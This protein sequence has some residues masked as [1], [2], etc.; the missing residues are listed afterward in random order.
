MRC[1]WRGEIDAVIDPNVPTV[2]HI[3]RDGRTRRLFREYKAE[4]QDY[5]RKTEI[6]PISH[7]VTLRQHFVDR[8]P[9]APVALLKAFRRARDIADVT[10]NASGLRSPGPDSVLG[11]RIAMDEQRALMGDDYFAYDIAHNRTTLEAMMHYAHEQFLN[12]RAG[13]LPAPVRVGG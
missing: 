2:D 6:F 11:E 13:R 8:H 5:F 9:G 3:R 10:D 1:L 12:A 7:V 4:E